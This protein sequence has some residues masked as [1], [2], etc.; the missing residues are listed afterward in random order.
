M[1]AEPPKGAEP[2]KEDGPVRALDADDIALLKTYGLGPYTAS[3][4]VREERGVGKHSI[5]V[6]SA[7]LLLFSCIRSALSDP[8]CLRLV[9]GLVS[10]WNVHGRAGRRAC[11]RHAAH[12]ETE[13][14]ASSLGTRRALFISTSDHPLSSLHS[15]P[16]PWRPT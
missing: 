14:E 3:I 16:R 15:H 9:R 5:S 4:K 8:R 12:P 1:P 6:A 2:D 11:G 7:R 13:R 10:T